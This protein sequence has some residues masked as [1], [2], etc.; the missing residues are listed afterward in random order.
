MARKKKQP[1]M[2]FSKDLAEHICQQMELGIN[3]VDI[4]KAYNKKAKEGEATLKP[5]TIHKWKREKPEFR[6]Q[7]N[8]AYESRIQ[9]MSEYI[10]ALAEE[11][12]PDTGDF[13]R[14]NQELTRRKI[15]ID[16]LKFTLAKLN[17]SHFKQEINVTHE[18]APQIIVQSYLDPTLD[19]TKGINKDEELH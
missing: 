4:C 10:N 9:Y 13:K 3:L 12:V 14:D 8:I 15:I 7:Y 2:R 17:A 6:E 19:V 1:L 18:N 5:N 11:P 16:T